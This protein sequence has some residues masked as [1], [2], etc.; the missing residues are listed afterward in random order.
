MPEI[1]LGELEQL[2]IGERLL[3]DRRR[4]GETQ[5]SAAVRHRVSY[6]MYGKWER[7]IVDC[8]TFIVLKKLSAAERC[9][10]YRRRSGQTQAAVAEDLNRC[11]RWINQMERGEVDCTELVCYWEC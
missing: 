11:R 2:T 3:I 6:F 1:W 10:L 8:P 7:D 9:L 5:T 4:R